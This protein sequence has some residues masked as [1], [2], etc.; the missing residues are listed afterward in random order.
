[1]YGC[2]QRLP[3]LLLPFGG[4][5][6]L[7]EKEKSLQPDVWLSILHYTTYSDLRATASMYFSANHC[8]VQC[9]TVLA[10]QHTAQPVM[11]VVQKFLNQKS[12]LS[13]CWSLRFKVCSPKSRLW[14]AKSQ[15]SFWLFS[16]FRER[17][18]PSF[19]YSSFDSF[20]LSALRLLT[21]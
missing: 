21:V 5:H 4:G 14:I 2:P 20:S 13:T 15:D 10:S 16:V 19:F 11:I 9:N 18:S 1:M 7:E 3:D 8:A 6:S 12:A 17:S